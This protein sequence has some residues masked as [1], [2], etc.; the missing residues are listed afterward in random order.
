MSAWIGLTP[1]HF[2]TG[3][4]N[5][6]VVTKVVKYHIELTYVNFYRLLQKNVK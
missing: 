6:N 5:T 3:G 4:K 2:G 1:A